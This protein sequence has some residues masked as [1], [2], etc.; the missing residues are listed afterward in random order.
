MSNTRIFPTLFF[1]AACALI[2]GIVIVTCLVVVPA[3][4]IDRLIERLGVGK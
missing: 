1:S 3:W 2:V 4:R